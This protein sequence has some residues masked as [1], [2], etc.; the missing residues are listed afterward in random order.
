MGV[1]L[2]AIADDGDL[3]ALDQVQVGVAIVVNSHG[4]F[5]IERAKIGR[6]SGI[7]GRDF[8]NFGRCLV[9]FLLQG[10]PSYAW[11]GCLIMHL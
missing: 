8:A 11:R 1:A 9:H 4:R 2:A 10:K 5:L 6:W 7:W 3:L